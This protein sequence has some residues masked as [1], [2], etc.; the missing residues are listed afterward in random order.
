MLSVVTDI[1]DEVLPVSDLEPPARPG[2]PRA[3]G[4]G[5]ALLLV[6]AI[7]SAVLLRGGDDRT[8]AERFAAVP[9]A[10]AED[11]FAFE[12]SIGG[13]VAGLPQPIDLSM[14]GA[15]DPTTKRMRAEM[16]MSALLPAGAGIPA[17]ISMV[18]EG[19]I[20]YLL[21]PAAPGTA[22]TWMK[23]D[24]SAL[25]QGAT[26]G[27]P[28]GTNPLDSF[29]QLKAVDAEIEEVGEE[30]VRGTTTTHYRTRI[31]MQ[32]VVDAMSADKRPASADQMIA[33]GEVPVEVWLDDQDR[34]RRQR[35]E[36]TLPDGAGTMTITIEAF[37]FGKP[38]KIELPPADQVVDGSGVLG[39]PPS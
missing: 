30:D 20:V 3:L 18:G 29:A 9:A 12:M 31:D 14:T 27:L 24:G 16:D 25:T 8:P 26:G 35:M 36:I 17:K 15:V 34:P 13:S 2:L 19:Q 7:V 28:T 4:V 23:V 33:I 10:V 1:A 6:A 32:K 22:P 39:Q 11:P 5:V 38:V 37:D 21:T